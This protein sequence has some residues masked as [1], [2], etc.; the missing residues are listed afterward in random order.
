MWID[1]M[2]NNDKNFFS[3]DFLIKCE[4]WLKRFPENK[5]RSAVIQILKFAQ[6]KNGGYLDEKIIANVANYLNIPKIFAYEVATFYSMFDLNK[7]GQYKIC[8][9]VSI[10]CMLCGSDD[11]VSHV[12]NKLGIDF[13]G[14]TQDGK[15]TLK[16][17]ECLAACGGAP[18][19]LIGEKYYENLTIEKIDSIIDNLE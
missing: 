10:S 13:D 11:I 19:V 3:G 5:K 2:S 14:T 4:D 17:V 7:V 6:V 12:K 8:F 1:N 18:V 9:C 16:K 15:F